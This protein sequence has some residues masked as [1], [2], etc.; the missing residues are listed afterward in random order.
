MKQYVQGQ[1]VRLTRDM[2]FK[3]PYQRLAG[4]TGVVKHCYGDVWGVEFDDDQGGISIGA[5]DEQG[6]YCLYVDVCEPVAGEPEPAAT[7]GQSYTFRPESKVWRTMND[8]P[9]IVDQPDATTRRVL[10]IPFNHD[11]ESEGEL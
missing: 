2:G 11:E 7:A 10:M 9:R 8:E 6:Q 3:G 4:L 5:D 1:R